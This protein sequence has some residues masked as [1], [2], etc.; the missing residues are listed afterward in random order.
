MKFFIIF[1][2]LIVIV[3]VI[4]FAL[5]FAKAAGYADKAFEKMTIKKSA[6]SGFKNSV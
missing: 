3:F 1:L 2:L 6:G 5:C 4:I